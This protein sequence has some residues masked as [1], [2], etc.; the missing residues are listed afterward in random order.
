[1][2]TKTF[3]YKHLL[4]WL[5]QKDWQ[6]SNICKN[7]VIHR[8]LSQDT[9]LLGE[10]SQVLLLHRCVQTTLY[11]ICQKHSKRQLGQG[12][13]ITLTPSSSREPYLAH[14]G[15]KSLGRN[16]W[17][18]DLGLQYWSFILVR[19]KGCDACEGQAGKMRK[20]RV[21]GL[22][23]VSAAW[24]WSW[25]MIDPCSRLWYVWKGGQGV[26]GEFQRRC[27]SPVL[28]SCVGTIRIFWFNRG[29]WGWAA[30]KIHQ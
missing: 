25:R 24:S 26:E 22:T 6:K 17:A 2:V 8:I 27:L 5:S 30:V 7:Q 23:Y 19:G 15:S 4:T 12:C 3:I 16:V 28:W 13:I 21:V 1:M 9:F 10:L 11:K 20:V 14:S 29:V 18:N